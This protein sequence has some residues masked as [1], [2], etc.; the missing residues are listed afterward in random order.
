LPASLSELD[1]SYNDLTFLPAL[2]ASLSELDCSYNDLRA[3]P[4][5]PASLWRLNCRSNALTVLDLSGC[6]VLNNFNGT[7]QVVSATLVESE[8]GNAYEV[9]L[10]MGNPLFDERLDGVVSYADGMLT[11]TDIRETMFNFTEAT[12]RQGY[13]L[14]GR[15]ELTYPFVPVRD[16][17]GVPTSLT[18]GASIEILGTTVPLVVTWP[19]N[20]FLSITDD[21]GT[22]ATLTTDWAPGEHNDRPMYQLS[23]AN[24]GTLI[25]TARV[26]NGLALGTD[27][28]QDFV[29]AVSAAGN[30]E[31]G[32]DDEPG[33]D[34]GEPGDEGSEP[35]DDDEPGD[36]DE[37]GDEGSE[38]GD[39]ENGDD[40][41]PTG[42]TTT[43]GGAATGGTTTGTTP[44][45]NDTTS[46]ADT[47]NNS[48]TGANN[49]TPGA[50]SGSNAGGV[51]TINEPDTP[52]T[53]G[54]ADTATTAE[55]SGGFP[56]WILALI[57]AVAVA[58]ITIIVTRYR[59]R[60]E[61]GRMA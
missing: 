27:Y 29:I 60:P 12:G 15:L 24:A 61:R 52:L 14:E 13:W 8:D 10:V 43:T 40:S 45:N 31:P 44:S 53:Q 19:S 6:T 59:N 34:E 33:D 57:A 7:G 17:T 51:N 36:G 39:T 28:T 22:G 32:D 47:G 41:T 1:C 18:A 55:D 42:G 9:P 11:S 46:G 54:N 58:T 48:N 3:L 37:P 38:P 49:T 26:Q 35:G 2:P 20:V 56:W 5:L 30:G 23:V 25:L 21:G 4:P 16:I 50:N